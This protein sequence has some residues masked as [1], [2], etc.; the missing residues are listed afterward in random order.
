MGQVYFIPISGTQSQSGK[1]QAR[2]MATGA[3]VDRDRE[4]HGKPVEIV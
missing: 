3:V 1:L 2:E 4:S